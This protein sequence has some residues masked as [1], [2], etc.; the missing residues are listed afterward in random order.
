MMPLLLAAGGPLD[1]DRTAG[2]RSGPQEQVAGPDERWKGGISALELAGHK[3]GGMEIE[4]E[5][6]AAAGMMTALCL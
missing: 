6:D 1:G 3:Q 4:M 2:S 5:M